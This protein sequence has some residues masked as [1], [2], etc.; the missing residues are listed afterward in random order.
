M[1]DRSCAARLGVAVLGST[2][3]IGRQTLQVIDAHAERF[4]VVGL[5]ARSPSPQFLEQVA[6]YQPEIAALAEQTTGDSGNERCV[7]GDEALL[8]VVTHPAVDI[9]VVATSGHAAIAPTIRAIEL[10]KTIALA[11]KETL[12]CAGEIIMPL[13]ASRTTSI[14]P[15]DSEHSAIWQALDGL[16]LGQVQRII[17][18]ASG[19]PFRNLPAAALSAVTVADALIHPTWSMGAKI[20]VDS[21]T[22]MNKGLEVIEAHW[23]FAL[24]YERIDVVVHPE[25]IVHSL[26]EFIDGSQIA[27]LGIPDMRLPIQY[28]LTYP[29]RLPLRGK[30]LDL[31]D[32]GSLHFEPPDEERFPAL[33]LAR[34][35]GIAGRTFPTAL[36]AADEEAVGGFLRGEIRFPEI[37]LVV[38]AVLDQH[39]PADVTLEAIADADQWAR[40]AARNEIARIR[41]RR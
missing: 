14:R 9:V 1:A 33:A 17:L 22:L 3:S 29:D 13:A 16:S 15:I 28:A 41:H 6:R 19:G 36:S 8:A 7:Y 5:A 10:D 31:R 24:P 40:A 38:S 23:L 4:R 26:V 2:G 32:I 25:S 34:A 18:T 27:Q 37:P 30:R 35:A 21:A 20:T 39:K 12:V 11:N